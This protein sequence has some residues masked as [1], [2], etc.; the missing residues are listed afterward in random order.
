MAARLMSLVHLCCF[1]WASFSLSQNVGMPH[2]LRRESENTYGG[3]WKYLT[4]INQI[5]QTL[6]FGLC[7]IIDF[8][9]MFI[10]AT[11]KSVSSRLLP[12]RDF[13][14]SVLVFPVGLFVAVTFWTL[15]AY[16]RELV[17]P[18]EL[19]EINPPWLNHTMTTYYGKH[20][21]RAAHHHHMSSGCCR[22]G[23][24][25][26]H[27][28]HSLPFGSRRCIMT[29]GH[30]LLGALLADLSEVSWTHLGRRVLLASLGEVG[31]WRLNI[32]GRQRWPAV[33]LH[34]LLANSQETTMA[35]S[36]TAPP[37]GE[38]PGDNDGQ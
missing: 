31:Q 10:P 17:Y 35:S 7:V 8:A 30:R 34:H 21:A 9:H 29:G 33:V 18:K 37:S 20:G 38:Q 6:L 24:A 16:D 32:N 26:L 13:I 4:F 12:P 3:R 2:S 15:Y 19:D 22:R 14:F 23:T 27:S 25:L 1:L 28:S 5:L 36:G 11:K